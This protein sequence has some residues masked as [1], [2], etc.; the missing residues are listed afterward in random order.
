MAQW[1]LAFS[2][3]R[4]AGY[5][6]FRQITRAITADIARG[7]LRPGARLPG[8]RTLARQLAVNRNTVLAAYADLTAEGWVTSS[9][10]SGTFVSPALPDQPPGAVR[11][12]PAAT[13]GF[14][15]RTTPAVDGHAAHP[16]GTIDLSSGQPD[17]ATIPVELLGR[18]Y[19]RALRLGHER[20]LGYCDP[21]GHP[22]LREALAEMVSATR[23]LPADPANVLV[24]RGSQMAW[25]LLARALFGPGDT[26]A[27]ETLGYRPAW[28]ALQH[29]GARLAPV[30]VDAAGLRVDAV[31]DLARTAQLRAV[32]VTP[33]RQYPTTVTMA[34]DRRM[35]LLE[36]ASRYRF[37]VIEDDYDHE[38]H[39]QGRPVQPLAS[40]DDKGTVIYV[41]TLSKVFAPGL[42]IGFVVAPASFVESLAAHRVV[43]DLAG[44]HVVEAAVAELLRDGEIQ[45]N[46]NRLRRIYARRHDALLTALDTHLPRVVR[47]IPAD[48]GLG[49]WGAAEGID[50]DEWAQRALGQGVAFYPG[51]RYAFSGEPL[52]CLRLS[53]AP[54]RERQ[55]D[56][57][58]RRM[59]RALPA[60][61]P[62]EDL[63]RAA[64]TPLRQSPPPATASSDGRSPSQ[65][66]LYPPRKG[67]PKTAIG[68]HADLAGS[69]SR[70]RSATAVRIALETISLP[71]AIGPGDSIASAARMATKAE[72]QRMTVAS[73][74]R[75]AARSPDGASGAVAAPS[76]IARLWCRPDRAR[77]R[78]DG[79]AR[80]RR[81]ACGLGKPAIQRQHRDGRRPGGRGAD[82]EGQCRRRA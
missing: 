36:L 51:R 17:L 11:V 64:R 69:R 13:P 62:A 58:V 19:R 1:Q 80:A 79:R 8:T 75:N 9:A 47:V 68:S 4:E 44:D 59:A 14:S 18:A 82:R 41:G 49:V 74:A 30:P 20:L 52:P 63:L 7:R 29:T 27:V 72:P 61:L 71:S 37:A 32:Y 76:A 22:R 55:I 60:R 43:L 78:P 67:T 34:A 56:E 42:R 24:T 16:R 54:L 25:T 57:A 81:K 45:R 66:Q 40:L 53:F 21:A 39:Y 31:D 48:G 28:K 73:P 65:A 26:V 12:A 23:S 50:V 33:H 6:V 77:T 15:L 10:A 2:L 38:F 46:V 35:R 70:R 5:P 3:D